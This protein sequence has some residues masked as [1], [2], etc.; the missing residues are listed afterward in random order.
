M[1]NQ[2][3]HG[4]CLDVLKNIDDNSIDCIITDIP[5]NI[6]RKNNFKTMKDRKGRNG[7]DFGKWDYDFNISDMVKFERVLKKGSSMVIFCAFEQYSSLL[8]VL[9]LEPK[10]RLIWNKTN[11]FPRNVNR[12]YISDIEFFCWFVKKGKKWIFNKPNNIPY[13][14]S[15]F[16]FPSESGGGFK[17]YHPTQKNLELMKL[18][19]SIH[20]NE[21][22]IILDPFCG[23]GT[24]CIAAYQLHRKFIGIEKEKEYYDIAMARINSYT[25]QTKLNI[26]DN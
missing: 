8:S 25:T 19:I 16:K 22:D 12:R 13:C 7:I 4:D 6:S 1:E 14:S 9:N 5:Y 26:N 21:N 11:P 10:D 24:T 3:I 23:S 2:I 20:T 17:R 15:I 18:L